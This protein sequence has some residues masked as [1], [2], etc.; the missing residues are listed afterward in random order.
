MKK[1]LYL[2]LIFLLSFQGIS[3]QDWFTKKYNSTEDKA[4]LFQFW[5]KKYCTDAASILASA[6]KPQEYTIYTHGNQFEQM[7][8]SFGTAI[9][10]T[11]HRKKFYLNTYTTKLS[12]KGIFVNKD[13]ELSIPVTKFYLS[14]EINEMVPEEV[15][16]K[17]FRYTTYVLS[18]EEDGTR[19]ETLT[20]SVAYGIFGMLDEFTA[21]NQGAKALLEIFPHYRYMYKGED[22]YKTVDLFQQ[23]SSE[24]YAR[25]EFKLFMAWY[26]KYAKEKY[27]DVYQACI[28]N[29]HLKVA[30]TLIDAE[31]EKTFELF[32]KHQN[33]LLEQIKAEN[34]YKAQITSTY[35]FELTLD[36]TSTL[37][38]GP[39]ED[40]EYLKTLLG[41]EEIEMLESITIPGLTTENYKSY[42]GKTDK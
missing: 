37:Y 11:C 7:V 18:Q 29:I 12:E 24:L 8:E 25:Y 1:Y 31:H 32:K 22:I 2:L 5:A 34:T 13:I 20:G 14:Y 6:K 41:K 23:V 28:N 38:S 10:E 39:G 17:I 36:N 19:S 27:P 42:L 9:H 26:L 3:A 40:I 16:E 30:Y 21:Y 35:D 4:K 15:S 33:D